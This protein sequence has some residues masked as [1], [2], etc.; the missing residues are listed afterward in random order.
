MRRIGM[1]LL[2]I[3]LTTPALATF[4]QPVQ[5]NPTNFGPGRIDASYAYRYIGQTITAC[6][7]AWHPQNSHLLLMGVPPYGMVANLPEWV[8]MESIDNQLSNK[9]ICV[10]G[11]VQQGGQ[12]Q[13]YED[14]GY[15]SAAITV[16]EPNHV[17][18]LGH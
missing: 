8:S 4:A 13:A 9:I 3:T 11:L 17:T 16:T 2:S 10:T 14:M 6:G 12:T 18:I 7:R 1:M 15:R 5:P